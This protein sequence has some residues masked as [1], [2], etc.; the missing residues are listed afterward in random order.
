M[1]S[2]KSFYK[3]VPRSGQN[4]VSFLPIQSSGACVLS[5]SPFLLSKTK[6]FEPKTPNSDQ[7][8]DIKTNKIDW[9][10][11][12]VTFDLKNCDSA[13]HV[14]LLSSTSND[15]GDRAKFDPPVAFNSVVSACHGEVTLVNSQ[16]S[17]TSSW[18]HQVTLGFHSLLVR[19]DCHW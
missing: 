10:L 3:I 8:I 6:S 15:G 4:G 5:K 18:P 2:V 17:Q 12:V 1:T 13:H 14:R 7:K 11:T 9:Y 19:L 16:R